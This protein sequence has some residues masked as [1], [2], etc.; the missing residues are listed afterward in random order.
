MYSC[1]GEISTGTMWPGSLVA[2]ASSPAAPRARYSVMKMDPPPATRFSTPKSPP[3]P[4]N[5]VWVV[6]WIELLIHESSP[7]SDM[8]ESLGSRANSR[9]GMVVPVMRLC[10]ADLLSYELKVGWVRCATQFQ[11][12]ET[13]EYTL[14]GG[15]SP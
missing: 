7:A 2:K 12:A 3:P 15:V 10:M 4:P 6:I 9:T 1:P 11:L 14:A 5:C 13:S 8:M